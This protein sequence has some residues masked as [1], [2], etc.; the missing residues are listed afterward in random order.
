MPQPLTSSPRL[1]ARLAGLAYLVI[2]AAGAF[3]YT[4]GAAMIVWHDA[5]ATAGNIL[6]SAQMWRAGLAAMLVMLLA[7]V[8]LACLFYVLF[9]PVSRTLALLGLALRLVMAAIIGVNL[10]ARLAPL[11]LLADAGAAAALDAA[12]AQALALASLRQFE[13]GF[14][15]ALVFFGVDCLVIGWLILRSTFMP[16][17]LGALLA[18]A[19]LAY[20]VN[21][22]AR[23]AYP[24]FDA[25][26][27]ILIPAYVA[28]IAL[29]LWLIVMGVNAAK[30]REQAA[31]AS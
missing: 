26:F 24:A 5:A 10:L 7:D 3:G 2:I 8:V 31:A 6:A 14:D 19:G 9:R 23:L 13:Y 15:I 11:L 18:L 20:L 29:C 30:W 16:R 1:L 28:E 27:D 12:E 21:S 4:T 22:F 17:L 25:P